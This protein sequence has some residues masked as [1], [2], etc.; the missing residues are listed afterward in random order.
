M[1]QQQNM[2]K[3]I[4]GTQVY[5]RLLKATKPYHALFIF[6]VLGTALGSA[7]DASFTW[8]VKPIIDQGF[9]NRNQQFIFWLPFV[10]VVV[11]TARSAIGFLSTYFVSKVGRSLVRDFRQLLFQRLLKLPASFYDGQSSG[12]LLSRIIFNVEQIA[13]AATDSLLLALREGVLAIG[14]IVVMFVVSWKLTLLFM[15]ITPVILYVVRL[16]SKHLR[17]QSMKVQDAMGDVGHIAEE[18]IEGYKVIR[19]FGGELYE[20]TKFNQATEVNRTRE[21]KIIVT[22]AIG[23]TMVQMI[24]SFVIALILFLVTLPSMKI[25]VGGFAA[26]VTAMLSLLRPIRRINQINANIQKGIA[27]AHSVFEIL[28]LDGEQDTGSQPLT[29]A[30]GKVQYEDVSFSYESSDKR[31]LNDINFTI[32]PGETV[33]L[34][35]RSGGGKSTI[36]NLMPRFYEL[37]SGRILIDGQDIRDYKLVDLREQFAL[38]SQHVT[39][40]NDTIARNIAYGRL[41]KVSEAEVLKAAKLAHAMPFIQ[42]MPDGIH[43]LIGENGV[44]LSGGQRQRIAIARAILKDAPILI[45]DEATSALDTESEQH[46]QAALAE[47]MRNRST[48]VIAHRLSTIE[49]ADRIIVIDQGRVLEAGSH[50]EL[51]KLN[52]HYARLCALQFG[53]QQEFAATTLVS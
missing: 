28:D 39:L 46:I 26:M 13:E 37:S 32:N 25:T 11:F 1:S 8:F 29:R 48:L 43:T 21:L 33:A 50:R 12:Q 7:V 5:L 2:N 49:N 42:D 44:L 47:L 53:Q 38:V 18:S 31:I 19:T 27:G 3:E 16:T 14:L 9:I 36:A 45:L 4:N 10:I 24:I 30:I 52:G 23:T 34:V 22:N 20:T 51:I 35:G 41:E 40:F 17:R 15:A 6:G